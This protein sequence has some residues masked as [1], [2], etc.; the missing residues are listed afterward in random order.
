MTPVA[1]MLWAKGRVGIHTAAS[2]R[3]E[4]WL[5][6]SVVSVSAVLIWFGAFGAFRE[7]FE[8]LRRF[9]VAP[10]KGFIGIGDI[11]ML[12]MVSVFSLALFLMLVFSNIFIVFSTLYRSKEVGF[13]LHTPT[14]IRELF[15]ARFVECVVFSSWASA[16]LGS[17]LVLAYGITAKAPWGFYLAAAGFYIPFVTVPAALGALLTILWLRFYPLLPARALPLT[18]LLLFAAFFWYV[19]SVLNAAR[20][21]EDTAIKGTG[22]DTLLAL[23]GQTQSPWLPS[24]W[25]A[26]GLISASMGRFRESVFYGLVLTANALFFSWISA[27]AAERFFFSGWSYVAGRS[28]TRLRPLGRGL[29]NRVERYLHRIPHPARALLVKD[30]KLFWR[31]ATQWTQFT[32]FFGIMTVYAATLRN[33]AI[34]E[35][36][37]Y[38]TW[39]AAMNIGASTLILA[40]LTSRFIFPLISL[41]GRRFWI[42]GLAPIT[43]RQLLAQKFW[44]SVSTTSAFTI[45][46]VVLSCWRLGVEPAA[47]FLAVYTIIAANFGLAGMAVGL[48]SLYPNFQEDNPARIVSG[49][50]GTLNFLLSIAY[51]TLLVVAETLI[52]QRRAL[53]ILQ[54]SASFRWGLILVV[55]FVTLLTVL[56]VLVPLRL[57]Y[58]HLA[59]SEF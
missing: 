16:Y 33:R 53:G 13:L 39:I 28:R 1:A 8:W 40:T 18:A 3:H 25:A 46:L 42:I 5:K 59:Q 57:G 23:S 20:L 37:H 47:F 32:V 24:H 9:D 36:E 21:S 19:R 22:I 11:V 48:G 14:T 34:P 43:F 7:G 15:I 35:Y 50:G 54:D 44:L 4:S 30:I 58:R 2:V 38:R 52:I 56:S 12:R 49:L 55:A 29:L 27:T 45:G 26:Q 31:D 51:I 41:E 6:I 17:P 10:G